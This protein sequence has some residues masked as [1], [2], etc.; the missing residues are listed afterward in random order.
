MKRAFQLLSAV[1]LFVLSACVSPVFA[2]ATPPWQRPAGNVAAAPAPAATVELTATDAQKLFDV[3]A[4]QP[5]IAFGYKKDGCYARAHLMAQRMASIQLGVEKVWAF[6]DIQRTGDINLPKALSVHVDGGGDIAWSYHVAP[7][8]T[9]TESD[10]RQV[11]YVIDPSLFDRPVL[12]GE[13]MGRM[14]GSDFKAPHMSITKLGEAPTLPNGQK[15]AGTGYWP[16]ADPVE[17]IDNFSRKVMAKYQREVEIETLKRALK[18]RLEAESR[19]GGA[20]ERSLSRSVPADT[21]FALGA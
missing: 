21:N 17:G 4:A 2:D 19:Q 10:G 18:A 5:D 15:A 1:L 7:L 3:L 16:G 8:V 20:V 9:V 12:I 13:W 11:K 6:A 14:I